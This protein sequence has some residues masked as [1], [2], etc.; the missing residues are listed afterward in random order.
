MDLNKV[1]LDRKLEN[2]HESREVNFPLQEDE[3]AAFKIVNDRLIDFGQRV[4]LLI[5]LV[6]GYLQE[7]GCPI[8]K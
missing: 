5:E 3:I 7:S 4:D 8:I 6:G 1:R 2:I